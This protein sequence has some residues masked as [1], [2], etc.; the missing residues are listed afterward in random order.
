[1]QT[2]F[3]RA[4]CC[5]PRRFTSPSSQAFPFSFPGKGLLILV[6]FS[7]RGVE[8]GRRERVGTAQVD[9]DTIVLRNGGWFPPLVSTCWDRSEDPFSP[10]LD[11]IC[12]KTLRTQV[13]SLQRD[14]RLY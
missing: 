12:R 2:N 1:M 8:G 4:D 3:L 9:V 5:M 14:L 13:R 6:C 7:Q 11:K 10:A